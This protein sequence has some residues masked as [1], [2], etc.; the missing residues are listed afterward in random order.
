MGE[1]VQIKFLETGMQV[2]QLNDHFNFSID[3]VL[4]SSFATINAKT[5]KVLE[6]G[7]GNGALLMLL[8]M[9]TTAKLYG[10]EI[11]ETSHNLAEKNRELNNLQERLVFING[12]IKENEKYFEQQEFDLVVSNPPFF[13]YEEGKSVIKENSNLSNAR[14]E[15]NAGLEDIVKAGYRLLKSRGYLTMVHRADRLTDI[16]SEMKKNGIEPKRVCY[17]YSKKKSDAKIV[18]VEGMKHGVE[19]L[20][21]MPPV[22]LHNDKGGYSDIV[23]KM[24]RGEIVDFYE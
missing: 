17:C 11:L 3:T 5:K 1:E 2:I 8:S 24:F 14:H 15:M 4:L 7:S 13:K 9:R 6:L 21:V 16:L 19:G 23:R 12:D 22:Y 18:L 20:K 10:L